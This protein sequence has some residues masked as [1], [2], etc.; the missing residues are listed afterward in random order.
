M[1][2]HHLLNPTVDSH[3]TAGTLPEPSGEKRAN[4][5]SNLGC[6]TL[7]GFRVQSIVLFMILFSDFRIL[8]LISWHLLCASSMGFPCLQREAFRV[9]RGGNELP[10]ASARKY[11]SCYRDIYSQTFISWVHRHSTNLGLVY[12]RNI[13]LLRPPSIRR[14]CR[15][16][17][18]CVGL[19]L[20]FWRWYSVTCAVGT[21]SVLNSKNS[22]SLHKR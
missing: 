6:L 1:T 5:S 8:Y 12:A 21:A 4:R 7:S 13:V 9:T 17:T 10:S 3:V 19:C 11:E 15:K 2:C 20:A 14:Y 18:L 22:Y 16:F